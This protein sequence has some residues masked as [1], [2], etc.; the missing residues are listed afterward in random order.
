MKKIFDHSP[1]RKERTSN[2]EELC[3]THPAFSDGKPPYSKERT[4]VSALI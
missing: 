4:A 3:E 1:K 2:G